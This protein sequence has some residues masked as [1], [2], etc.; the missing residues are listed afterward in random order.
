[1]RMVKYTLEMLYTMN[2]CNESKFIDFVTI[3]QLIERND[4]MLQLYSKALFWYTIHSSPILINGIAQLVFYKTAFCGS[5][6][7][8]SY[9][10]IVTYLNRT[11]NTTEEDYKKDI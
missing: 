1:M 7:F 8:S 6:C 2:Y 3:Q 5:L 11:H 10:F 9:D 4:L